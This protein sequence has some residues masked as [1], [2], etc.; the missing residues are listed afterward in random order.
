MKV[1]VTGGSG[2]VGGHT[3]RALDK[4]GYKTYNYDIV[5]GCD[6]LDLG[7]LLSIIQEGDFVLHEA[8]IARFADADKNPKVAFQVNVTGT[9]NVVK[10][11]NY[12]KAGK[13]IYASTGSVYMPIDQEPPITEDFR[14]SGNS[15]YACSKRMAENFIEQDCTVPWII[16]RY[17]HL[18]GEGKIGHG[19]I[20]GFIDK[21]N[22]KVAPVLNGGSQTNDFT[23]IKDI[24]QANVKALYCDTSALNQIYNIGTGIELSTEGVFDILA[25]YFNYHVP[26]EK[27][28]LRSVDPPRFVF[29][30]EKAR[31]YL[32]YEPQ[33]PFKVGIETWFKSGVKL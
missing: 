29:S 20:G 18:Y 31:K 17:G 13:L 22:K 3:L 5:T 14:V 4:L 7:C 25:D 27:K 6:L 33:F 21:M 8:A 24:I 28:P 26:Y 1:V 11:C 30:I 23:Y 16:L 2:F 32:K 15:V 12:N 10:A 19:A 9:E